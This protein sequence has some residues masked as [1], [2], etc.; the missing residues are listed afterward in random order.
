M[1]FIRHRFEVVD[2]LVMLEEVVQV[3]ELKEILVQMEGEQEVVEVNLREVL[4]TENLLLDLSYK[5]E[6]VSTLVQVVADIMVGVVEIHQEPFQMVQV[7][8]DQDIL[9]V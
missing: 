4:E 6:L 3:V 5:V 8:A 1:L 9:V 7:V 2:P